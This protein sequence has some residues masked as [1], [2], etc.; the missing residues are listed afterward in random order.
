VGA[1]MI[2][3]RSHVATARH[4]GVSPRAHVPLQVQT[5]QWCADRWGLFVWR[6]PD[7]APPRRLALTTIKRS[8]AEPPSTGSSP[9]REVIPSLAI[10]LDRIRAQTQ[11]LEVHMRGRLE[12]HQP[13]ERLQKVIAEAR[14][15]ASATGNDATRPDAC[16]PEASPAASGTTRVP[17]T[18]RMPGP[19]RVPGTTRMPGTT[20][21]PGAMRIAGAT[22]REVT[23][24]GRSVA[25]NGATG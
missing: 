3:H 22:A 12:L 7:R 16:P 24:F 4:E 18:T 15:A 21:V 5:H 9:I 8:A 13:V 14:A 25:P 2:A 20:R 6:E 23:R 17:G 1:S 10:E 19:T 11:G